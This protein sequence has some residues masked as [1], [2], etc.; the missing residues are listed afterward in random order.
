MPFQFLLRK[1]FTTKKPIKLYF[2]YCFFD[3]KYYNYIMT[4]QP[5][6]EIFTENYSDI[7]ILNYFPVSE[8]THVTIPKGAHYK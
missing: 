8:M 1:F 3:K 5:F 4:L 7:S 6:H 2:I